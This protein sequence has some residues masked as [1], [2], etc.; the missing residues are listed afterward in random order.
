MLSKHISW[1]LHEVSTQIS[2]LH[3]SVKEI[4]T[5]T[6][7]DPDLSKELQ[8]T[9]SGWP[10][11]VP[12]SLRRHTELSLEAGCILLGIRVIVPHDHPGM[13]RMISLA[14]SYTCWPRLDREI[15]DLGLSR[16]NN[17]MQQSLLHLHPW[18]WPSSP[19]DRIHIDFAGP[20]LNKMSGGRTFQ[21]AWGNRNVQHNSWPYYCN[22]ASFVCISWF[23]STCCLR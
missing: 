16:A 9:Q 7:N 2:A 12:E 3:V 23:T 22:H 15:E 17:V 21:M 18:A 5:A 4:Q 1:V 14:R 11:E 6:R 19:W 10:Q 8:Y 20:F 13:A